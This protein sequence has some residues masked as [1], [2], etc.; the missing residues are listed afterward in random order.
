M[1]LKKLVS[2]LR[3]IQVKLMQIDFGEAY[4]YYKGTKI[5]FQI[6]KTMRYSAM[7]Y[8]FAA[9]RKNAET[10]LEGIRRAFEFF[11]GVPKRLIFDN[12]KVAVLKNYGKS[13]VTQSY[14]QSMMAHYVFTIDFC[15]R[16]G[17]K[18]DWLKVL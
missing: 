17:M 15:N 8:V 11:G 14:L 1:S 5:L 16:A 7:P 12:D 18:K 4:G 10:F 2:R 6:C 9:P 3:L 13:A